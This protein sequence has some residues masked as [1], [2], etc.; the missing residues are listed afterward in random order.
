MPVFTSPSSILLMC[1]SEVPIS[2]ATWAREI[3]FSVLIRLILIPI[4]CKSDI[5]DLVATCQI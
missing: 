3:P 1:F 5:F 4:C 2:K